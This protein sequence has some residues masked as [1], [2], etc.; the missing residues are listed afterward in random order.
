MVGRGEGVRRSGF[1]VL[2]LRGTLLLSVDLVRI[3][4]R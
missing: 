2:I 1:R 4:G 3:L